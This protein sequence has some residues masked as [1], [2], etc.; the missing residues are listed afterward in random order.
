MTT[1]PDELH[2]NGAQH[3]P[4]ILRITVGGA[5]NAIDAAIE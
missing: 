5:D 2:E 1:N 4:E 3:Y